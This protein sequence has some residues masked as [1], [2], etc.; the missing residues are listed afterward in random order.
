MV[1]REAVS[2]AVHHARPREISVQVRFGAGSV[3]MQIED[4]GCGFDPEEILAVPG[5]HFG[6]LGMRERIEHLGGSFSLQSSPGHGARLEVTVPVQANELKNTV[7]TVR[8]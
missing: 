3:A 8:A 1:A 7:E 4:D 2:N 6:I 5:T